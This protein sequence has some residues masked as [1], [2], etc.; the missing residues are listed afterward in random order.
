MTDNNQKET[1]EA[2]RRRRSG[3]RYQ[4]AACAREAPQRRRP[5]TGS[6]TGAAG[7]GGGGT[8]GGTSQPSFSLPS[9]PGGKNRIVIIGI[10]VLGVICLCIYLVSGGQLGDLLSGSTSDLQQ[11]EEQ[12]PG[13]VG[14]AP[15]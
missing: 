5:S 4:S 3:A 10:V 8:G 15:D 14:L 9:I 6:T 12:V 11:P 13:E 1:V 7:T 2:Q